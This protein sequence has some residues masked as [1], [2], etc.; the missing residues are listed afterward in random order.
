MI[1]LLNRIPKEELGHTW[2]G[3]SD[4]RKALRELKLPYTFINP[5]AESAMKED[6]TRD[7]IDDIY[8]SIK[9]GVSFLDEAMKYIQNEVVNRNIQKSLIFVSWLPSF[10]IEELQS[11]SESVRKLEISIVGISMPT[12]TSISSSFTSN[13]YHGKDVFLANEAFK[14][15]WTGHTNINDSSKNSLF[16]QWID[17]IDSVPASDQRKLNELSFF[18]QLAY[19]RGLSEILIIALFNPGI[20]IQIKGGNFSSRRVF[21]TQKFESWKINPLGAVAYTILSYILST[22]R[23]LPNVQFSSEP[24]KTEDE[25]SDAISKTGAIFYAAKLPGGSGIVMKSLF[26]GIPVIWIG[27]AGYLFEILQ[28]NFPIGRIKP[29]EI[30]IPNQVKNKLLQVSK[31]NP[32]TAYN[33]KDFVDNL[34]QL[35]RLM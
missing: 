18:G 2:K 25:L 34:A 12:R 11:L 4:I 22:L 31:Q 27:K 23:F 16:Q 35:K 9:G 5:T 30:Y 8:I 20:S 21:R 10:S 28:K 6:E 15:I 7:S 33:W 24:F 32:T 19:P 1:Y 13:D 29:F 17:F 3:D 14:L 26:S